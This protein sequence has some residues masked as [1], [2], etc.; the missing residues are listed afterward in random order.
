MTHT[1]ALVQVG[2]TIGR[3]LLPLIAVVFVSATLAYAISGATDGEHSAGVQQPNIHVVSTGAATGPAAV[4]RSTTS[5][6]AQPA[7]LGPLVTPKRC[8]PIDSS[9]VDTVI[10]T[11]SR[12]IDC[13][14]TP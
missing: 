1:P 9:Y 7:E 3:W 11:E 8:P 6:S 4:E 12:K 5:P 10:L 2:L 13:G 14:W